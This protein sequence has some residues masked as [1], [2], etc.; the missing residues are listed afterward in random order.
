MSHDLLQSEEFQNFLEFQ[1]FIKMKN[2]NKKEIEEGKNKRRHKRSEN[3]RK[4]S[5]FCYIIIF[6]KMHVKYV[7][8]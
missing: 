3:K 4:C 7:Y 1:K 8:P 2:E 5:Q 6:I